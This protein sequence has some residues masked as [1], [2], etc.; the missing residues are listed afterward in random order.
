MPE[1]SES[2]LDAKYNHK[3]RILSNYKFYLTLEN[4]N[5][6]DYVTEKLVHAFMVT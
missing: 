6:T 2:D 1:D 5:L 4:V 3:L